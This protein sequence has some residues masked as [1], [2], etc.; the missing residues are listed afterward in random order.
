MSKSIFLTSFITRTNP[1]NG[2]FVSGTT[3]NATENSD[4]PS[5]GTNTYTNQTFNLLTMILAFLDNLLL[6]EASL[7][8]GWYWAEKFLSSALKNSAASLNFSNTGR[9]LSKSVKPE[10]LER[11]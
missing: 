2:D 10:L 5:G 3:N 8:R 7:I 11:F 1:F 9:Q 4:T 6:N